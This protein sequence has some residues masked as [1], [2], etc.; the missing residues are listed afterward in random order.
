[1]NKEKILVG[2]GIILGFIFPILGVFILQSSRP[3]F[4]AFKNMS[5]QA[6][7]IINTR[8]LTFA[9]MLDALIF[10]LFVKLNLD[11]IARGLLIT[12]GIL[13]ATLVVFEFIL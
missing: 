10:F 13:L 3:E 11:S 8:L 9:L 4:S 1:M 7:I 2:V 12:T 5:E 6:S